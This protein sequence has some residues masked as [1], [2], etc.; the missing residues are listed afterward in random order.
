MNKYKTNKTTMIQEKILK[1]ILALFFVLGLLTVFAVRQENP[2]IQNHQMLERPLLGPEELQKVLE[3]Q[4]T[5][6]KAEQKTSA[7]ENNLKNK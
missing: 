5:E 4:R 6:K 7:K 3:K 1:H 2:E